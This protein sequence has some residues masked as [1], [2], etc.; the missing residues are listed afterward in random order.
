MDDRRWRLYHAARNGRA[1]PGYTIASRHPQFGVATHASGRGILHRVDTLALRWDCGAVTG[2]AARWT[3]TKTVGS[4]DLFDVPPEDATWCPRCDIAG[5][6]RDA[7]PR[8]YYAERDGLIKIGTSRNVPVR[9]D[10]LKARLLA[11]EPGGPTVERTRH[12]QFGDSRVV[13]EWFQPTAGLH[14]H[15]ASLT[16]QV[17]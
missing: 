15:I 4:V 13:G 2:V 6:H 5:I 7:A 14:A 16:E 10:A 9:M 1:L 8:V 17:A 12:E 3:C 11:I